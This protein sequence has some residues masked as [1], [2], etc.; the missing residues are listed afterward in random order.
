MNFLLI[1]SV[2]Q[3]L[4]IVLNKDKQIFS[5]TQEALKKHN[6]VLLDAVSDL[7]KKAKMQL[8]DI[9]AYGVVVG[10]GSFTG[11]R[12]GIATIKAFVSVFDK[13]AIGIN[14]LQL[15]FALAQS[16]NKKIDTV[17]IYGSLNS[18][19]V[20]K[21]KAGSLFVYNRNLNFEEL[22]AISTKDTLGMYANEKTGQIE[23]TKIEWDNAV[24]VKLFKETL[25][26]DHS[27]NLLPVY[28]QLSQAEREKILKSQI[29]IKDGKKFL[30]ELVMLDNQC[31]CDDKWD[32]SVWKEETANENR[33]IKILFADNTAAG[34]INC[35]NFGDEM[36]IMR[37]CTLEKFRN[38]GFASKLIKNL[39]EYCK[40]N[41]INTISLEVSD[42][43]INAINLYNKLGFKIR[44]IRKNYYKD[45]SDASELFLQI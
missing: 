45:N 1:N 24:F 10:P 34:Y 27:D 40:Q 33:Y 41:K 28:Y 30:T 2:N 7:L 15:L 22:K 20:A 32:N 3:N 13:P 35:I 39:I 31:F 8:K 25:T 6:E 23:H 43:N 44:R 5:Y 9:G 11:I 21:Q 37:I 17:A 4:K 38:F 42:K 19:F 12:V 14:N 36:S 16:Q 18:Y 29:E 26:K